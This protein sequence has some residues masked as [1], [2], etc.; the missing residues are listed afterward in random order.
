[1][2]GIALAGVS[3]G[4]MVL[5]GSAWAQSS[6]A[7][8]ANQEAPTTTG[9]EEIVVSAQRRE[10]RLQDVPISI[11]AITAGA[12]EKSGIRTTEQL[13]QAVPSLQ[14]SRNTGNGGTPYVRGVG[15]SV[16]NPGSSSPVAL[17]VDDVY[18]AS[19]S[20]SVSTLSNIS[21]VEVLKGPQG[22]LFGR[23][24][25]G[26][27]ISIHTKQPTNETKVDASFGYGNFNT[28]D[29]Y[30][31]GSTGLTQNLAVNFAGSFHNQGD[32]YGRDIN[33]G[34]EVN[35]SEDYSF[36]GEALW[37]PSWSTKVLVIADYARSL[38][39][40]GMNVTIFPGT[41]ALGGQTF[42]GR[43]QASQVPT[44]FS[45]QKQFGFS[46][47]V[48]QD[49]GFAKLVSISA[50]RRADNYFVV[51]ND[52]GRPVLLG[53]D[54]TTRTTGFSQELQIQS[55]TKGRLNWILGGFYYHERAGFEPV[56]QFGSFQAA[57]GG[58]VSLR[59]IQTLDS[60][61]GF[62]EINY[63]VLARTR[64]TAGVR[65]TSDNY[66]LDAEQRNASGALLPG[67]IVDTGRAF[68][69]VTY[70]A[71]LDHHFTNGIMAYGSYSRGFKSGGYNTQAPS[72][73]VNGVLQTAAPVSPEV[74]DAYEVGLKTD[75]FGRKLEINPSFYLYRYNNLQVSSII[76][77]VAL[78]QN[79]ASAHIHGVDVDFSAAPTQN[80]KLSGG[81]SYVHSRFASFPNGLRFVPNPA[82]CAT[83]QTTGP[84]TGGNASCVADLSGNTTPRTPVFSGSINGTYTVPTT[85]GEFALTGSYYHNSGF[86]WDADNRVKQPNYNLVGATLSWTSP[87]KKLEAQLWVRN[88][89]NQYYYLYASA[90]N[91]RDSGAPAAPRTFGI[92]LSAHLGR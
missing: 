11:T 50:Y 60:Y 8:Q 16:V 44:D 87:D 29:A 6:P 80:F 13:T 73:A 46:A 22:T 30:L 24:A 17:Y 49:V 1:M 18:I 62:G 39:D 42:P 19:A 23:N 81:I 84:L 86:Y 51:D 79:A 55:P 41:V 5:S 31:Y 90:S 35:K 40:L 21:R 32:G 67:S 26:G 76:N 48:D 75:F 7:P 91:T 77:G 54:N 4:V 10:Q 3:V 47:K 45:R 63:D 56:I 2:K 12:A 43:Y 74:I 71:V 33:T 36:R 69:K 85:A 66:H 25:T 65:Y 57:N 53:F 34:D 88:L 68:S 59:S 61:S 92:T 58:R 38:G 70:R 14:F 83:G 89:L 27:V 9:V 78:L 82:N 64:I 52:G 20:G 72:V 15:T 28:I 37:T